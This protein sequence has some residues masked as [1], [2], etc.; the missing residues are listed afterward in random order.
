MG[1]RERSASGVES[2]TWRK[3]SKT[4][5]YFTTPDQNLVSELKGLPRGIVVAESDAP[6]EDAGRKT[7]RLDG[8]RSD[9][10]FHNGLTDARAASND[11]GP[12]PDRSDS[13]NGSM[14]PPTLSYLQ[15]QQGGQ[16]SR[17]SADVSL[18]GVP[19]NLFD[20]GTPPSSV[21]VIYPNYISY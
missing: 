20:W 13:R 17:P 11:S 8:P 4:G 18:E 5:G 9:D 19:G 21:C 16:T 12:A 2:L 14:P 7:P 3:D 1:V 6:L 15:Q 10:V